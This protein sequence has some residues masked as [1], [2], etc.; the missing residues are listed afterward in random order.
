MNR[1]FYP[2]AAA[3]VEPGAPASGSAGA[4]DVHFAPSKTVFTAAQLVDVEAMLCPDG[5]AQER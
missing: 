1:I 4:S 2:A 3:S 5:G